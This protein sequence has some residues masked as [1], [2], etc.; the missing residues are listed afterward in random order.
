MHGTNKED[1][2]H[3]G[4][5]KMRQ[6]V[7]ISYHNH[8]TMSDGS[9]SADEMIAAAA[10]AGLEEIGIS[11]HYVL[12][13]DGRPVS[14]SMPPDYLGDYFTN[15]KLAAERHPEI[16][17][18]VGLEIDF[19]PETVATVR[20]RIGRLP[21]DYLIGAVHFVGTFP[22]DES[23]EQWERLSPSER[24]D[25]WRIYWTRVREMAESAAF[26]VAAH[27]DLPKKFGFLPTLEYSAD[28]AAA[29]TAIAT[30]GMA[31]ELNTAGWRWPAADAYPSHA[32]LAEARRRDIRLQIN[33]DAHR[34]QDITYEGERAVAIAR[35]LGFSRIVGFDAG[36]RYAVPLDPPRT[37]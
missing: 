30:S 6:R 23:P 18:R 3:A 20:D 21:F 13:P 19:F 31:L 36:R 22:V 28:I 37:L 16:V 33:T 17:V 15:V 27:L 5:R 12:T 4:H 26:D 34:P 32:I 35:R 1:R 14:W 10:A 8:T 2:V 29:L 11:D 25:I 7:R 9:A 24:D